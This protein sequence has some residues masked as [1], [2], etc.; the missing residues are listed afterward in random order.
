M[1]TYRLDKVFA[2][3]SVAVV[4]AS[5][6]EKS[7]GPGRPEQSAPRRLSA[8]I[9]AWSIPIIDAIEGVPAVKSYDAAPERHP[10]SP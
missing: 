1:S 8:A 3:R 7:P 10:I 5:P 9:F 4:G 6:R 2:P